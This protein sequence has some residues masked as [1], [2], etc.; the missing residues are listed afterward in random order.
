LLEFLKANIAAKTKNKV[1]DIVIDILEKFAGL[2][3]YTTTIV[4]ALD[5]L[6]VNIIPFIAGAGVAGIA[7]GFAAKDTLSGNLVVL[8]SNQ[9][10][11]IPGG[12]EKILIGREDPV[13]GVFPDIDLE[14]HGGHESGV[15]RQHAQLV[16]I[17]GQFHLEDLDSINGT[18]VNKK[19]V[20]ANQ[21]HPLKDGDL[22]RLGKIELAFHTS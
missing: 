2:I 8:S 10:I 17:D 11:S 21:P 4:I 13:S 3:V 14:P 12:K 1:D 9:S 20:P 5:T 7:I 16:I 6:G 22:V 15:G 18:F 19:R